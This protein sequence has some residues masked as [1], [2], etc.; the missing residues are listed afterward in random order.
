[1][2]GELTPEGTGF[3]RR[4]IETPTDVDW[5]KIPVQ[6]TGYMTTQVIPAD[7]SSLPPKLELFRSSSFTTPFL[8]DDGLDGN[9]QISFVP[10]GSDDFIWAK[11]SSPS[12]NTG[13]YSLRT[14]RTDDPADDHP[15]AS[16]PYGIPYTVTPQGSVTM[17]GEIGTAFDQDSFRIL[18]QNPGLMMIDVISLTP[19][20]TPFIHAAWQTP[21][22]QGNS[23]TDGGSGR[24]GRAHLEIPSVMA[25]PDNWINLDVRHPDGQTT[26]GQYLIRAWQPGS[27][28]DLDVNSIGPF[29]T[30][31]PVD[32]TGNGQLGVNLT[33]AN[34]P[35]IDFTGD[36]DVFQVAAA[37]GRPITFTVDSSAI[38]NGTFLRVYDA[39][40]NAVATDNNSDP[41][42][43]SQITVDA[44]RGDLYYLEVSA[45]DGASLGKYT[46]STSQPTDDHPDAAVFGNQPGPAIPGVMPEVRRGCREPVLL[47]WCFGTLEGRGELGCDGCEC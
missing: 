46:I 35:A 38:A 5:F 33:D 14:W 19:G 13:G 42:G 45:F 12:G 10:A 34:A 25:S 1:M 43:K 21:D 41:N 44:K 16:G 26:K 29:A 17:S 15:N 11:V 4:K 37:T 24:G 9:T 31:I 47:E 28:A 30:P 32:S 18:V 23:D 22:H 36:K 39:S 8:T 2:S 3:I 20:F 40:G 27:T 6:G 7:G